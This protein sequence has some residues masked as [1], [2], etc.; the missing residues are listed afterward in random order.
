MSDRR[1]FTPLSDYKHR[2]VLNTRWADN[3][4]YGHVNNVAYYAFFDTVVNTTLI[5]N[6]LLDIENGPVIGLVVE[7]GCRYASPISY[8][9]DLVLG[10]GV[11]RLGNT[12]V[13]YQLAVT[14]ATK[15]DLVAAEGRFVHVYVDFQTRRPVSLP[16]DMRAFLSGL[17]LKEG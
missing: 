13:H 9:A 16:Q 15:P 3:D 4:A 5:N 8:P 14:T 7:T 17:V 10:L 11:T 12:S 2:H 1:P 6:G